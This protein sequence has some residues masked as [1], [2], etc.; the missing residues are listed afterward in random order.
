MRP[1]SPGCLHFR[2]ERSFED[3]LDFNVPK[4]FPPSVANK[5]HTTFLLHFQ[6]VQC[7][8]QDVPMS[9]PWP[10]VQ[11]LIELGK[12]AAHLSLHV[13]GFH[14]GWGCSNFKVS[15]RFEIIWD[16]PHNHLKQ[17]TIREPQDLVPMEVGCINWYF[18]L[19]NG[20]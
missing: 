10:K 6:H 16:A 14:W 19:Y 20:P 7:V 12:R 15:K 9:L 11:Y 1:R 18:T 2:R 8:S 5:V 17:L 4:N 13:K 3:L